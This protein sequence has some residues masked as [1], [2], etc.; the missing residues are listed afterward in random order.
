M[1]CC[2]LFFGMSFY[3]NAP[4]TN[5]LQK[6]VGWKFELKASLCLTMPKLCD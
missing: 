2:R 1:I 5:A 4:L 3:L 6:T